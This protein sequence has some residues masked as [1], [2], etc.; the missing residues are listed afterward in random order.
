MRAQH[1]GSPSTGPEF[2]RT[3]LFEVLIQHKDLVEL[4]QNGNP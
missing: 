1:E 3:A 4:E 2:N